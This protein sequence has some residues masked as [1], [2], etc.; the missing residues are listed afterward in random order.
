MGYQRSLRDDEVFLAYI[1][2]EQVL[3]QQQDELFMLMYE[4]NTS[5]EIDHDFP[6]L[7]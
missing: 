1:D 7:P 6:P 3:M 2:E 5:L 4:E